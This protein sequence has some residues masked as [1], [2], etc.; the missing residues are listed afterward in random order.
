MT[1]I[2]DEKKEVKNVKDRV[3]TERKLIAAIGV[4]LKEDGYRGLGLNRI[5]KTAGVNKNLIYRYFGDVDTLVETYI[6]EKDFW[7]ADNK[8]FPEVFH[9][10]ANKEQIVA[11]IAELLKNQLNFFYNSEEMQH[12]I[13]SEISEDSN[14][15]KRLSSLR[16]SMAEPFFSYTDKYFEKSELNFRALSAIMTS[17]IYYMVLQSK[18]NEAINC[19][20]NIRTEQGREMISKTIRQMLEWSFNDQ[21]GRSDIG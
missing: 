1:K 19:G 7:L 20:I 11:S 16:E 9:P 5:A 17:G 6:R 10:Q 3:V 15:L 2:P 12:I 14:I 13:L 21:K 4:I 18:K 8:E